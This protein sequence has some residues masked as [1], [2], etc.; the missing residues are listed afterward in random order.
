MKPGIKFLNSLF[1][2]THL[3]FQTYD[4]TN[5]TLTFSSGMAHQLLGYT[6]EEYRALSTDFYKPIIHPDDYPRVLQF[7]NQMIASKKG[8]VIELTVRVRKS[9]GD[10]IWV[11]SRQMV[12][13]RKSKNRISSIIRE[14]EDVTRFIELRDTLEEKVEQLKIVSHKNSHLLRGPVASI[15]GLVDL[16]EEQGITSEHN[17]QILKY[18]KETITKLD[19]I[20]HEINQDAHAEK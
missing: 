20:V 14:V 16:V 2:I 17:R 10:Y 12:Y 7:I 1:E 3:E 6:K 5:K 13:E 19:S 11:C 8:E 4:L 18:L 15:I 9:D